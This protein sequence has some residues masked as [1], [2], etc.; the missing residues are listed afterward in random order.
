MVVG[1]ATHQHPHKGGPLRELQLMAMCCEIDDFC[2]AFVPLYHRPLLPTA[3]RHQ[4]R[5]PACGLSEIMTLLVYFPWSHY[6][7][8]NH[9]SLDSGGPHLPSY[10]VW[11]LQALS[12][13][14]AAGIGA[15]VLLSAY[16]ARPLYRPCLHCLPPSGGL[17]D[18][19]DFRAQGL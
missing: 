9:Y 10:H 5:P 19:S 8:F 1:S 3:Q 16:A 6:R 15:L 12:R 11:Q 7:T 2:Q 4:V 18:P 13:A 17:P 14:E